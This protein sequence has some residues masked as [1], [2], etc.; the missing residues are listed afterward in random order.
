MR[1]SCRFFAVFLAI[2]PTLSVWGQAAPQEEPPPPKFLESITVSA[3]RSPTSVKDAPASVSVI[4]AARIERE[5]VN[6][7][8]DL[9]R[10]EPGVYVEN[11]VTRLGLSGFNIRGIGGNR[12]LTQ[13]DGIPTAEQFSFG[14]LSDRKSTR[15]NSSHSSP[16]RMPSSA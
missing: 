15:L 2:S 16:S 9:V 7:S 5:M 11:D 14:P 12:V 3:T 8:R 6:D 4:D 13:V 10:Y 1:V